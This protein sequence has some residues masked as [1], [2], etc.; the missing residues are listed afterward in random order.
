MQISNRTQMESSKNLDGWREM[1]TSRYFFCALY[2][3]KKEREERRTKTI[4][5]CGL[6]L[7][8]ASRQRGEKSV[9]NI[10]GL[11]I[12]GAL[13][14]GWGFFP[15][16]KIR[17]STPQQ[18]QIYLTELKQTKTL[19]FKLEREKNIQILAWW[20]LAG[21]TEANATGLKNASVILSNELHP[22]K[23]WQ[24]VS[25]HWKKLRIITC[26]QIWGWVQHLY[27]VR[28]YPTDR[29]WQKAPIIHTPSHS[30]TDLFR[31]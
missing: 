20:E 25:C 28:V 8:N 13:F 1:R 14:V 11:E 17:A 19:K 12:V 2:I 23:Q 24:E 6:N 7:A 5:R 21:V 4:C 31:C 26:L 22:L 27:L 10:L 30:S 3:E 29:G 9:W 15:H 16:L 18:K